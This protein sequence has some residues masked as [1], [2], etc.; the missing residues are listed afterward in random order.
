MPCCKVLQDRVVQTSFSVVHSLRYWKERLCSNLTI[1][2]E[3]IWFPSY[4][5]KFNYNNYWYQSQQLLVF[6]GKVV[7]PKCEVYVHVIY[8]IWISEKPLTLFLMI[9]YI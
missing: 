8:I 9:F 1:N 6:A 5:K 2:Q 3:S 7:E 4:V